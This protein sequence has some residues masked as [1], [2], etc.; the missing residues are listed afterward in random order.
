MRVYHDLFSYPD[1]DQRFLK[2]IQI[3]TRTRPNDTDPDTK[4]WFPILGEL[5]KRP[6]QIWSIMATNVFTW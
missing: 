4:H 3:R 1:P 6:K 5:Y 2:W